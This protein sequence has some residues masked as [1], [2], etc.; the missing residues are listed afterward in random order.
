[1]STSSRIPLSILD[2]AP[3]IENSTAAVSLRNSLDLA[4]HAENWSYH[5][6]WFAEHHNL[7]DVASA[8]TAVVIGHV[9]A[10]TASIRIGSGGIMLDNHAPLI[11]AEQFGTLE[12]LFPGRIDLG[13]GRAPGGDQATTRAIRRASPVEH[14]FAQQLEQLQEL[15]GTPKKD[16][17]LRAIPG[18][19]LSVPIWLL[20]SSMVS[21]RL[22]AER[23]LPFAFAAHFAPE[24][25]E[26]ALQL[27]RDRFKPSETL[28]EPYAIVCV[29][30]VAADSNAEAA[31]LSSTQ[32][33]KFLNLVQGKRALLPPPVA[34]MNTRWNAAEHRA[35]LSF[36]RESIIGDIDTVRLGLQQL[37]R[38]SGANELMINSWIFSHPKRLRSYE[39]IAQAW[40]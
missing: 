20:G 24:M 23:G 26:F 35:V 15:L 9:A 25:M 6:Y 33:Q 17:P 30:V 34:D 18:A 13:L 40:L 11:I 16:Q 10:G 4:R 29:N 32:Q 27:Y 21:A 3:I 1:M 39:L 37:Q 5:R 38:R 36:L 22:A 14:D 8:A 19:N 7:P 12:S 2:L 31:Y 28:A